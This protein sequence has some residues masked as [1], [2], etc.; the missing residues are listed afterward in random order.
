MPHESQLQTSGAHDYC[1]LFL[2]SV[3]PSFLPLINHFFATFALVLELLMVDASEPCL[4]PRGK[5]QI[6]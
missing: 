1:L 3:G 2:L 6:Q 4:A 5:A